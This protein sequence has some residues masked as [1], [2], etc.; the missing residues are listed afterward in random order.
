MPDDEDEETPAMSIHRAET[1]WSRGDARFVDGRYSRRHTLTFV[2]G[3][4]VAGTASPF[5]VPAA[6]CAEDAVD[7]EAAFVASIA[8]C[9]MLWFLSLAAAAGFVVDDYRDAAEGTLA[10]D[11]TGALAIT[12]VVLSPQVR[13]APDAAP[14]ASVYSQLH[15]DAHAHCF[16]ARSV[17]SRIEIQASSALTSPA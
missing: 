6:Y 3:V 14:D 16:I 5:V 15:R 2:H 7:P 4:T 13:F 17:R 8:S 12:T 10:P 11:E 1:V 9:H